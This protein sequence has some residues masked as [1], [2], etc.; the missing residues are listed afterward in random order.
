MKIC[1]WKQ[2][3]LG[4]KWYQSGTTEGNGNYLFEH[5][6]VH[7]GEKPYKCL[8]CGKCFSQNSNLITHQRVHTGEKPYKC[9][10]CGKCF[11]RND[12]LTA[13]Q[14]VH[15][16]EKPYKCLEC[17]KCFSQNHTLTKH[18]RVHTGE[19][20]YKCLDC[21]KCFSQNSSL[22]SHQRVHTGE[23]PYKCLECGKCFSQNSNLIT[24]KKI[25]T[26]EKPYKCLE[27]G[28]CFS[29]NS[30]LISH[31]K[32]HTGE[33][34]H[35][36]LECG[37]RSAPFKTA[38]GC[39]KI[40]RDFVKFYGQRFS[41]AN[42]SSVEECIDLITKEQFCQAM[43]DELEEEFGSCSA[44]ERSPV[45]SEEV[46]VFFTGEEWTL[47]DSSQRKLFWEVMKE[48][49]ETVASLGKD[50]FPF[51]LSTEEKGGIFLWPS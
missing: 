42:I 19:K 12:S 11:S 13:H 44:G 36:C 18:Q 46:A 40:E 9:L 22:I 24:H 29:Q 25:H 38:K 39:A 8:E 6:S 49:Y 10:D 1:R 45:S 50:L 14:R 17:G 30:N 27:C 21:E 33:K 2:R 5:Q 7:T 20:P 35:K 28:N 23:K 32:V 43:N 51:I 4:I 16:G 48:N 3:N 26:G 31:K 37:K 41:V 34:P 15:T 47:L